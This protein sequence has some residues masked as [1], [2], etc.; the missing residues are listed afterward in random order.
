M[1][2]RDLKND[3]LAVHSIKPQVLGDGTLLGTKADLFGYEAAMVLVNFGTWTDGTHT[4][5]LL[6]S[7]DDSTYTAVA[8]G[9]LQGAFAAVTSAAND[10]LVQQVGYIGGKRYIKA[11][12][13]TTGATTGIPASAV[14][15]KGHPINLPA[16]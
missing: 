9:N 11:K 10:D 1:A 8:A 14:L 4:P 13:V 6:E 12:I 2:T 16:A 3:V 15:V 5:S 7:D